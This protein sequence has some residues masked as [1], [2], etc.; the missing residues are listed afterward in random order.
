MTLPNLT[1]TELKDFYGACATGVA[2]Q[3]GALTLPYTWG[4][5]HSWGF[6]Y[7]PIV[8]TTFPEL[9]VSF[10]DFSP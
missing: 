2:Y 3:Q 1:F 10:L 9:A 4:L 7:A 6:A 8:E 5:P